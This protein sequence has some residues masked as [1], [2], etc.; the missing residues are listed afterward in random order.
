[1]SD[2]I[3]FPNDVYE[4]DAQARREQAARLEQEAADGRD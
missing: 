3:L 4:Q 2:P 1:M